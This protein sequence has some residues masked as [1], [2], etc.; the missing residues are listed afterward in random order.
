MTQTNWKKKIKKLKKNLANFRVY[1]FANWS[2]Y[3]YGLLYHNQFIYSYILKKK[4]FKKFIKKY[5]KNY[6]DNAPK[7]YLDSKYNIAYDDIVT[8]EEFDFL[9][10]FNNKIKN[11]NIVEIGAGYGRTCEMIIK[12][13]VPSTYIIIDLKQVIKI[14]KNYLKKNLSRKQFKTIKFINFNDFKD[15]QE[16]V[17][18]KNFDLLINIDSFHEIEKKTIIKYYK[19]FKNSIP[20]F[21]I[22]NVIT[23][24]YKSDVLDHRLQRFQPR[25][26]N[27]KFLFKIGL[28]NEFINI[29][30]RRLLKKQLKKYLHVYN[31]FKRSKITKKLSETANFYCLVFF[32][33]K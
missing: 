4:N 2:P 10:N 33:K 20:N 30:D 19:I 15:L 32:E 22:K 25:G 18:N 21:F 1:T 7:I 13:F 27:L 29:F 23:K 11:K 8:H 9:K 26:K 17:K 28:I 3:K 14:A 6:K 16:K 31:P 24:Y 5:K 12:E